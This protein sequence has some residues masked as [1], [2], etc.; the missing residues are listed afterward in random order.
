[1]QNVFSTVTTAGVVLA[2]LQA[3]LSALRARKAADRLLPMLM[4]AFFTTSAILL[5]APAGSCLRA[6]SGLCASWAGGAAV[7]RARGRRNLPSWSASNGSFLL[8]M[9]LGFGLGYQATTPFVVF[10][11][12]G[13]ALVVAAISANLWAARRAFG[14][15]AVLLLMGASWLWMIAAAAGMAMPRLRET[16]APF[17]DTP[18]LLLLLATGWLVMQKGF[19]DPG[20]A[21]DLDDEREGANARHSLRARLAASE[22]ALAAHER[23]STSA[24]LALGAAHEFKNVL[25]HVKA[26]AQHGLELPASGQESLRLILEHAEAGRASAIGVL[27]QAARAG[28]E[29]PRLIDAA[30]DLGDFIRM[31]R[32]AFRAQGIVIE[33][34]LPPGVVFHARRNEVE[35]M[36]LN[37]VG[38]AAG[39]YGESEGTHV[40]HLRARREAGMST[41][42]V[43]D[44]AGGV[45]PESLNRLF[46]TGCSSTGDTG[47][48]L[49]LSKSLAMANDGMLEYEPTADGSVF[50]LVFA[51]AEGV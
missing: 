21:G 10:R 23:V 26:A 30:R 48:G 38:N 9:L 6:V 18:A 50:R 7:I 24:I 43:R 32:A 16:L 25:A 15:P 41:L 19:P 39:A 45:S 47:L 17:A 46:S 13:M 5:L 36:L 27:E 31:A 4:A 22:N 51:A 34:E 2:C 11:A 28:R 14:S 1:M 49:Y 42:E 37:L 40:I 44:H 12:V 8:V 33:S 20:H 3:L 35:Q 29:E